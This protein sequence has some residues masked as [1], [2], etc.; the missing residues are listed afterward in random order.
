M[1]S[2]T[3]TQD[4]N[5]NGIKLDISNGLMGD[6][7]KA[8]LYD[9]EGTN[10]NF[11][12]NVIGYTNSSGFEI[13]L[14]DIQGDGNYK[15]ALLKDNLQLV[16]N[17][18]NNEKIKDIYITQQLPHGK[19]QSITPG[20]NKVTFEVEFDTETFNNLNTSSPPTFYVTLT[21]TL[22]EF[23]GNT[24]GN[25]E[26]TLSSTKVSDGI[27]RA[28]LEDAS[29]NNG[30]T[31]NLDILYA[32]N[33]VDTK[34]QV[35]YNNVPRAFTPFDRPSELSVSSAVNTL[36]LDGSNNRMV[37]F[38][39]QKQQGD[40]VY[41]E[42]RYVLEVNGVTKYVALDVSNGQ[43]I[44]PANNLEIADDSTGE[45][46]VSLKRDEDQLFNS[47]D[48]GALFSLKTSLQGKIMD[49]SGNPTGD[50]ISSN[51]NTIS[52]IKMNYPLASTDLIISE[53]K[54]DGSQVVEFE[55]TQP[56]SAYF[57][58][59]AG[60]QSAEVYRVNVDASG[61][62]TDTDVVKDFKTE[63]KQQI[64]ASGSTNKVT[65]ELS[66][67]DLDGSYG[68]KLRV[69]LEASETN[70]ESGSDNKLEKTTAYNVANCVPVNT[71]TQG[72]VSFTTNSTT[73]T[74]TWSDASANPDKLDYIVVE[75]SNQNN[76][77]VSTEPDACG[78]QVA[79]ID[80][81]SAGVKYRNTYV[82]KKKAPAF[83]PYTSLIPS[84]FI[85]G[86]QQLGAFFFA[87]TTPVLTSVT[88]ALED[89][90]SIEFTEIKVEGNANGHSIK[91]FYVLVNST[92]SEDVVQYKLIDANGLTDICDNSLTVDADESASA[93][94]TNF[95]L[96][97]SMDASL[98]VYPL[99]NQMSFVVMDTDST[100]DPVKYSAG[101]DTNAATFGENY[102]K[103]KTDIDLYKA[104]YE[105]T[106]EDYSD[107]SNNV[108]ASL[109][110]LQDLLDAS[111]KLIAG[112]TYNNAVQ[113]TNDAFNAWYLADA[114]NLLA[115]NA[116]IDASNVL[117]SFIVNFHTPASDK[118]T[119][120][121]AKADKTDLNAWNNMDFV[122]DKITK[123]VDNAKVVVD[124][125]G[126]VQYYLSD[127]LQNRNVPITISLDNLNT[128]DELST[129]I[130]SAFETAKTNANTNLTNAS[131]TD[132]SNYT[133][134]QNAV[135]ARNTAYTVYESSYNTY[136]ALHDGINSSIESWNDGV[137]PS[138]NNLATL[139]GDFADSFGLWYQ[140]KLHY[141]C[142]ENA[143]EVLGTT[144][145]AV[146]LYDALV[147]DLST[148]KYELKQTVPELETKI[149]GGQPDYSSIAS[150][151]T[152][153]TTYPTNYPK[154]P[155]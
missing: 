155:Q 147:D 153:P 126:N 63:L 70:K 74:L 59:S 66:T 88:Y 72:T 141:D 107:A 105:K 25:V 89:C 53:V 115:Y 78:N 24:D 39:V 117:N 16:L 10:I 71:P 119:T 61:V 99:E 145:S 118:T 45:W 33:N 67:D 96:K 87:K 43:I 142:S 69:K 123:E 91:Q 42:A 14:A 110:A 9:T 2:F 101:T 13:P 29:L 154:Y 148:D 129:R 143:Y 124:E 73:A 34:V 98:A 144:Q 27:Y 137:N 58:S 90:S 125:S 20:K 112:N 41:G 18:S 111:G 83:P 132:A 113:A 36:A 97:F 8:Q 92:D 80:G 77:T 4:A 65:V 79:V 48:D 60:L 17:N 82:Y 149:E 93:A 104:A 23:W 11:S 81:L 85:K 5:Y 140:S 84:G 40:F 32:N 100:H 62:E 94:P 134:F 152:P 30:E 3:F 131:D 6:I 102:T 109:V 146:A 31:Y 95:S 51:E 28:T 57:D 139:K 68:K 37:E 133:V 15:E 121:Q 103:A 151:P 49:G 35:N 108:D 150:N 12:M 114:S 46:T 106:D 7:V 138:L 55:L 76:L 50:W 52:D 54:S 135:S 44:N 136:K 116:L 128:A 26:V 127:I 64:D 38:T 1:S 21:D 86:T 22:N 130:E 56:L 122:D 19:L 47:V 75:V 120:L